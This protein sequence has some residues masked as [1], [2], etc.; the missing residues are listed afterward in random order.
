MKIHVSST[1]GVRSKENLS[2]AGYH[3]TS[4]SFSFH[5]NVSCLHLNVHFLEVPLWSHGLKNLLQVIKWHICIVA[6]RE[7]INGIMNVQHKWMILGN[8]CTLW[9]YMHPNLQILQH[10]KIEVYK[11][12][13]SSNKSQFKQ[14]QVCAW[15]VNYCQQISWGHHLSYQHTVE[16]KFLTHHAKPPIKTDC[17]WILTFI[18]GDMFLPFS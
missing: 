9:Q 17:S 5:K 1:H 13:F 10:Y 3:D 14:I 7:V 11:C 2:L 16:Q 18:L 8:Y 4:K 12:N 6:Y 15:Y